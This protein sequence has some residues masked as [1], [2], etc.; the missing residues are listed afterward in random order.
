MK[1]LKKFVVFMLAVMVMMPVIEVNAAT[2]TIFYVNGEDILSAAD[3]TIQ[4][5]SG[6][7]VYNETTSTLTLT[8][9]ELSVQ[10]TSAGVINVPQ[11]K[12]TKIILEGTNKITSNGSSVPIFAYSD[13][14]ITGNGTLI[15]ESTGSVNGVTVNGLLKIVDTKI[16]VN[17]DNDG[18]IVA[19]SIEIIDSEVE[20]NGKWYDFNIS[21][22]MTISNSKVKATATGDESNAFVIRGPLTIKD[23]SNVE[24]KSYYPALYSEGNMLIEDSTIFAEATNDIGIWAKNSALSITGHS[25]ITAIGTEGSLGGRI[26]ATIT[27][28]V[29]RKIEINAGASKEDAEIV[30]GSPFS[31]PTNLSSYEN[32]NYFHSK[33]FEEYQVTV[34]GGTGDKFYPPADMVEIKA[35]EPASGYQ[36][37][38]W[39]VNSGNVELADATN[40]VTTFVMP[41]EDVEVTATW[42][43]ISNNDSSTSKPTEGIV[44]RKGET[45]YYN[46]GKK[47][48]NSFL[49]INSQEK[50]IETYS[51]NQPETL[52]SSN[53]DVYFSKSDG[54]LA[55]YEWIVINADGELVD[56]LKVGEFNKQYGK[57]YKIYLADEDGKLVKSWK[58]T[59]GELFYFNDDYSARFNM[60][61]AHEDEWYC[62]D[63]YTILTNH[64]YASTNGRWY[65]L[66][67]DGKMVKNQWVDGCW[68]NELGVYWSPTYSDPEFVESYNPNL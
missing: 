29:D 8:N 1:L 14:E 45:Y 58:N 10:K 54:T 56:T 42:K 43:A 7:A 20:S 66:D 36:F 30:E 46:K 2:D 13:I 65:Y 53:N 16:N 50:L 39:I 49:E 28:P 5:G 61:Q 60:W 63:N 68:V 64:W 11:D 33:V 67:A 18:V 9:A 24:A 51:P 3:K 59:E 26:S 40:A 34:N 57:D 21:S 19:D 31:E 44:K 52:G 38:K 55:V 23:D 27:P 15:I 32:L 62:F 48:T 47:V 6:T 22:N 12:P 17:V 41:S 25:D 35:D 37:S 4:C